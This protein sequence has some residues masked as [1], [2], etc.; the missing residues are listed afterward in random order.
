MLKLSITNHAEISCLNS[1][2]MPPKEGF[3]LNMFQPLV[4]TMSQPFPLI[5]K[6]K[7][8][9][10]N[11]SKPMDWGNHHPAIPA[12]TCY[13]YHLGWRVLTHH[14][15]F[16]RRDRCF[17]CQVAVG[18]NLRGPTTQSPQAVSLLP[19]TTHGSQGVVIDRV[20]W[21]KM[22]IPGM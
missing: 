22:G 4:S 9:F 12:M 15:N 2:K 13:V 17:R 20:L 6:P 5:V 3:C 8:K 14:F 16:Q 18:Q 10:G 11:G 1:E 7:K 21:D 19:D